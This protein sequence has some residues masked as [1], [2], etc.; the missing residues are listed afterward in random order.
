MKAIPR[1]L[2][3]VVLIPDSFKGTLSSGE[4]C[5][6]LSEAVRRRFPDCRVIPIP[7]ADGGEGSVDAFLA[8]R[9]GERIDVTVSG[10]FGEPMT[11]FYGRLDGGRTAVIEMAACAGL[12][13]VAGRRDPGRTTTYGVGELIRHAVENGAESVVVGLGGSATSDGGCGAAAAVGVTFRDESG[14][15]FIPTGDTLVRIASIDLTGRDRRL[16]TVKLITMC[17]VDS[18]MFGPEGA[19]FVFAPQK[20]ANP[21]EVKRL[22]EGLRHLSDVIRRDLGRD[23]AA[24]PGA[25][26]AGAM[27]AGMTAFFN[28]ETKKGIEAVLDI[29]EF[30]RVIA[31]ADLIVTG[32]GK[33]DAQSLRGK[34]VI[35]VARRAKRQGKPV[36]AIVGGADKGIE[37]VYDEGVT[38]VF[39]IN[40][41]PQDLSV[42]CRDAAYNLAFA[43]DNVLRLL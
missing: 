11:A 21:D 18:P 4:I 37:A 15:P 13:L 39:T 28:A 36:V 38:A 40:R 10:P 17:D 9:G 1:D 32:E 25:G 27:G 6:I 3:K 19:A 12:P 35:G 42:S 33:L 30:D 29:V 43:A 22:D 8:A 20:G 31:D 5:A 23:V 26:A 16:D 34:A 2:R 41:L 14:T 7:V 24:L